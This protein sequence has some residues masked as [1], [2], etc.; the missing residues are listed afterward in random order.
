MKL[1]AIASLSGTFALVALLSPAYLIVGL[2]GI[3]S[4]L[5]WEG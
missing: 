2:Y 1:R 4:D 5:F 3:V